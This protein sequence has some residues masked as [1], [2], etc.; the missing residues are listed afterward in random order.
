MAARTIFD[1]GGGAYFPR[2]RLAST[3]FSRSMAPRRFRPVQVQ[4]VAKPKPR[5]ERAILLGD[6]LHPTTGENIGAGYLP[7]P[8]V[9]GA[10][11]AI[12]VFGSSGSGKSVAIRTLIEYY[13]IIE[14]RCVII[15]DPTKNQ[16]WT[17]KYP[18]DRADMLGRLRTSGIR[19]MG[20]P[21][22]QVFVPI[23]DVPVLGDKSMER[24]FKSCKENYLSIRT[25]DLTSEGMFELGDIDPS[26]KMYQLYLENMLNVA[27]S[28]RTVKY[29]EDGLDELMADPN[30]KRSIASLKNIFKPLAAMG[31][32]RDDGTDVKRRMMHSP[33]KGRPGQVS[34]IS[35]GTSSASDRRKNAL[36]ASICNQIFDVIRDDID[37][38]PVIVLDEAKEFISAKKGESSD[39]TI[40]GFSRLHLQGRAW[41]RTMIYGFQNLQDV[42]GWVAGANTPVQIAMSKSL[43][44]DDGVTKVNGTGL[45]HVWINGSGDVKVPDMDFITRFYPCRTKHKD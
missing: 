34:I 32:I 20:I 41:G 23:Y 37:M 40:T 25:A 45:A 16:Y 44:L 6:L 39:A 33:R 3:P 4:A 12:N 11:E 36:V 13:S 21:D 18:Q 8:N 38:R 17:L 30:K 35:L 26:G 19:P 29:I 1:G 31:I 43:L 28:R 2:M 9:K 15:F 10:N 7:L 22:V 42:Q 14:G 27:K 24:D 5:P